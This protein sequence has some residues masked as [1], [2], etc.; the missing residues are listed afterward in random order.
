MSPL[1]TE[2][3]V[4]GIFDTDIEDLGPFITS[5]H[6][7]VEDLS[8]DEP[9]K[10]EIEKWLTAHL[11]SAMDR[12]LTSKAIE[13]NEESYAGEYGQ[14]LAA[15]LYGQQAMVLDTGNELSSSGAKDVKFKYVG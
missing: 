5:A 8:Y 6:A 7:L 14:Q 1:V 10:I 13:G 2:D 11:A 12:E 3:D 15:T 9:R 4:R